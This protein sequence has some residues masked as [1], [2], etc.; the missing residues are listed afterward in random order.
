MIE[1]FSLVL[2]RRNEQA[3]FASLALGRISSR[4]LPAQNPGAVYWILLIL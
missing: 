1:R 3:Q 4:G 2:E